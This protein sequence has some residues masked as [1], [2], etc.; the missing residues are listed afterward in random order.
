[1]NYNELYSKSISSPETF[2]AEQAEQ[3]EWFK[4]PSI[5]LSKNE[6]DYPQWFEDGEVERMLFSNR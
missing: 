3:L 1:M 5:I 2:W 4:K 6:N